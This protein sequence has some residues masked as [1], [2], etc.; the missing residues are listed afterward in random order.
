MVDSARIRTEILNSAHR[1]LTQINE[2]EVAPGSEL[3]TEFARKSQE[4]LSQLQTTDATSLLSDVSR[5]GA[6]R[7]DSYNQFEAPLLRQV[8]DNQSIT[9]TV[10]DDTIPKLQSEMDRFQAQ[11]A[12]A[13]ARLI[14]MGEAVTRAGTEI[15]R[16]P[17]DSG[18]P[19]LQLESTEAGTAPDEFAKEDQLLMRQIK[20]REQHFVSV[21]QSLGNELENMGKEL[22]EAKMENLNLIGANERLEKRSRELEQLTKKAPLALSTDKSYEVD[23]TIVIVAGNEAEFEIPAN[24]I[25]LMATVTAPPIC[26]IPAIIASKCVDNF[27]VDIPPDEVPEDV[28]GEERPTRRAMKLAPG[29][30]AAHDVGDT[31]IFGNEIVFELRDDQTSDTVQICEASNR[32]VPTALALAIE[33]GIQTDIQHLIDINAASP[34]EP[35]AVLN[36]DGDGERADIESGSAA[37]GDPQQQ[38]TSGRPS[39]PGAHGTTARAAF[40]HPAPSISGGQRAQRTSAAPA[41]S[42]VV[43]GIRAKPNDQGFRIIFR[44]RTD[45]DVQSKTPDGLYVVNSPTSVALRV[46]DG[47]GAAFASKCLRPGGVELALHPLRRI[48]IGDPGPEVKRFPAMTRTVVGFREPGWESDEHPPEITMKWRAFP[49]RPPPQARFFQGRSRIAEPCGLPPLRPGKSGHRKPQAAPFSARKHPP[50]GENE[51]AIEPTMAQ[52]MKSPRVLPRRS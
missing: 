20:L 47:F 35:P 48:V 14:S 40:D 3:T 15:I 33:R 34:P 18:V 29:G 30:M 22:V 38:P 46:R 26:D 16:G 32:P 31:L 17:A 5:W 45:A 27:F 37:A 12:A 7:K 39:A 52:V 44:D 21:L 2:M 36:P 8:E 51:L 25:V 9:Q 1:I 41:G 43:L 4:I 28:Q 42:A 6:K 10:T 13:R 23:R 24:Q 49:V 11:L 19:Q 50:E